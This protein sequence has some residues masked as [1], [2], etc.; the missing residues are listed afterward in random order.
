MIKNLGGH[1]RV[2]DQDKFKQIAEA[3]RERKAISRDFEKNK[4]IIE[5]AVKPAPSAETMTTAE[6]IIQAGRVRRGEIASP[7]LE[8]P[9]GSVAAEILRCGRVRRGEE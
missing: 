6:K 8:P 2:I 5:A 7:S 9:K 1:G 3:F 4:R